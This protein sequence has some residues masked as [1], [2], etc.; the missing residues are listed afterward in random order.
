M[1][2]YKKAAE[3]IEA[4]DM[5]E[6]KDWFFER[7]ENHIDLVRKY[8]KK[9]YEL[10]DDRFEGIID[11]GESHDEL[12]YQDPELEPYI[13]LTWRYK[14]KD[15]GVD[16]EMPDGMEERIEEATEHHVRNHRHHPEF[17]TDQENVINKK[18]RDKPPKDIV[19]ATEMSNLDVAEMV[20]DW[21]AMSEERGGTPKKWADDNVNIRWKFTDKQKDI[22]YDL[23]DKIWE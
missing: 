23:I 17:H 2:W 19:D 18:D 21:C 11:R 1:N 14:C 4:E 22:I 13:Y 5:K 3:E 6:M 20:C 10:D 15:D 7:T 8:C 12:K 9:V 16:F